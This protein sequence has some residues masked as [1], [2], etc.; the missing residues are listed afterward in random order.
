M[1]E[2]APPS[3]H[4]SMQT[5][6]Q[7]FQQSQYMDALSHLTR[8]ANEIVISK[9]VVTAM[10]LSGIA[11]RRIGDRTAS[12][13]YLSDALKAVKKFNDRQLEAQIQ[14]DFDTT[15]RMPQ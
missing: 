9:E 5:G 12:Y 14:E 13:R 1:N 3:R 6:V 15:K 4:Y 2:T 11:F 10:H 7:L 8:V